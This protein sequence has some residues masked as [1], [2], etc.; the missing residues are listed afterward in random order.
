M[1]Q[2]VAFRHTAHID[3]KHH[4]VK[5]SE[6]I[7]TDSSTLTKSLYLLPYSGDNQVKQIQLQGTEKGFVRNIA[8][9]WEDVLHSSSGLPTPSIY[10]VMKS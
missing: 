8:P 7:G 3:K 1:C 5:V 9:S 4:I 10:Q 6:L 2:L